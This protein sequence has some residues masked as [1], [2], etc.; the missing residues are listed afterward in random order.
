MFKINENNDI[1]LNCH[2][3]R[4]DLI[5]KIFSNYDLNKVWKHKL[6]LS[7]SNLVIKFLII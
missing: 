3:L 4:K 5:L 6:K 2:Y 1:Y 7:Y